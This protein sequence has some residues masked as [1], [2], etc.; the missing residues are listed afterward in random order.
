MEAFGTVVDAIG[1][2]LWNVGLLAMWGIVVVWVVLHVVEYV[3]AWQKNS[4][5]REKRKK[6]I[7]HSPPIGND[8]AK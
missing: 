3:G 2:G 7:K 8:T 6:D 4:R 1:R 5:N